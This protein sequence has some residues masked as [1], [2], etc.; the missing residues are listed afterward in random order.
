MM[1]RGEPEPPLFLLF[2]LGVAGA[3][4]KVLGLLFN[5]T[6]Q[7]GRERFQ[8]GKLCLYTSFCI[9]TNAVFA[10]SIE[11]GFQ[12]TWKRQLALEKKDPGLLLGVDL[13]SLSMGDCLYILGTGW[14][15][16]CRDCLL[17]FPC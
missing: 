4:R 13:E 6:V 7:I 12:G 3:Q 2:T 15:L 1:E 11:S 17:R 16:C 10:C 9:Q 5:T 14:L 8:H